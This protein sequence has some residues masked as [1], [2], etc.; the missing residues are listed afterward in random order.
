MKYRE[1]RLGRMAVLVAAAAL[2]AGSVSAAT[3]QL[4]A[5]TEVKV[6]FAG[7]QTISSGNVISGVPLVIT[8][9]E[10]IKIGDRVL[11][12][13]GAEGKAIVSEVKKAGAPGKPG[14]IKVT[15]QEIQTKGEFSTV[16]GSPIKLS[17]EPLIREGKGKKTLAFITI[18]GIVLIKGGQGE[19]PVD[20]VYTAKTA[21]TVVLQSPQ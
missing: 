15:F 12:E 18:I 9:A 10:P 1:S 8:L 13:T 4:P 16:D 2:V 20:Q 19:I 7:S 14:M 11:V 21:E 6:K 17:D 3:F 5:G